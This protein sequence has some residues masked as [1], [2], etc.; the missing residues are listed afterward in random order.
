MNMP[1]SGQRRPDARHDVGPLSAEVGP[2]SGG[3]RVC[4]H[5]PRTSRAFADF[6]PTLARYYSP[7]S[8]R[9]ASR[10]DV[11]PILS[12]CHL[13]VAPI[14]CRLFPVPKPTAGRYRSPT[15]TLYASRSDIGT[16]FSHLH[17]GVTPIL[18]RPGPEAKPTA[19]RYYTPT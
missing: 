9:H 6:R 19:G 7:S 4:P 1:M 11:G 15:S 14:S 13:D 12:H 3:R 5:V 18:C 16:I 10:D 17:P 8:A 2:T